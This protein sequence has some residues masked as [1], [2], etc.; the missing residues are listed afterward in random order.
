MAILQLPV[1]QLLD[2]EVHLVTVVIQQHLE[3]LV[4]FVVFGQVRLAPL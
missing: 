2:L 4:V 1:E 3:A